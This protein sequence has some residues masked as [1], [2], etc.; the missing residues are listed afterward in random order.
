MPAPSR[1]RRRAAGDR[2]RRGLCG[3][4]R[5]GRAA[6]GRRR[7]PAGQ[8]WYLLYTSG[9]TG[10]P[11]GVVYVYRMAL[12][13]YVNIGSCIDLRSTDVTVSF[14]PLFHTAGINL[15]AL[16]TLI[17]GGTV[18]LLE[19]FDAEA[20]V[21][22][23]EDRRLDTLFAVPTVYQA[24]LDHPR[25]A[26]APLGQVRH[27]GCGGAPLPDWLVERYR[28]LGVRVCNGMG[29]TETGPTAFLV[30]P[31]D[32][33]ERIGSVGKPQLLCSVRIVDAAG[34]DVADGE[35]GDLLFAG[36]GSPPATGA[37]RRRPAPPS[38]PTAG[39]ARA[40]SPAATP[41]ASI[42]SPAG[43][44]RCSS[45]GRERLSGRG[46]ERPL[47][48]SGGGRRGGAERAGPEMGARS[49]APSSSSPAPRP[50]CAELTAFCRQR[51][52]ALQGAA[53]LR[54]RRRVPAHL[55]RQDPEAF[56]ELRLP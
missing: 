10:R 24:L 42:I 4:G 18:L 33:W 53:P 55:G 48:P 47:R 43:G 1:A 34:R 44:R 39:C 3:A 27:W 11:K 15:H 17:A 12:A 8:T 51:L 19:Q 28:D 41:T 29:M 38:P 20:L 30:D 40:T 16:P 45:R 35:V 26:A 25:F 50:D 2:P 7:W 37:T 36:R 13:N 21:G 52:A 9:T 22:L 23:I 6:P 5:G 14:L 31:A 46:R 32:A 49:A 54:V 56:A